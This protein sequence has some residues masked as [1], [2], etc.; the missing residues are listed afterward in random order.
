MNGRGLSSRAGRIIAAMLLAM[1]MSAA[2]LPLVLIPGAQAIVMAEDAPEDPAPAEEAPAPAPAEEAPAPPP[3]NEPEPTDDPPTDDPPTEDSGADPAGD[4]ES[5]A[6]VEDSSTDPDADPDADPTAIDEDMLDEDMLDED[7]LDED[8]LDEDMLDEDMLDEDMLDETAVDEE[9]VDEEVVDEEVVDEEVVEEASGSQLTVT[10]SAGV[11]DNAESATVEASGSGL[12]PG[13]RFEIWAFSTP[14]L[15]ATDLADDTGAFAVSVA[16]PGDLGPGEHSLLVRGTDADGQPVE[17][18]TGFSIGPDG[19]LTSVDDP[20]DPATLSAP[21]L[22]ASAKAPPYEPVVAL[23]NPTAV[24][25]TSI[26]ALAII[27]AVG[28]AAGAA[29]SGRA[30]ARAGESVAGGGLKEGNFDR[31][32]EIPD[33][34]VSHNRGWMT[35]FVPLGAAVGDASRLHRSP[36]TSYVDEGSFVLASKVASTSPL[37]SRI[38]TDG[39]PVRAIF[40]SASLLLP[41]AGVIVGIVAALTGNGIAQ[42]PALALLIILMAIGIV[43]AFAGLLATTAFA[44]VVTFSGGIIGWDSLRTL[45]GV[46]LLLVGPGIIG[47]SFRNIRR[48]PLSGSSYLWERL[49]DIVIVPLFAAYV[50]FNIATALPPLGGAAFPIADEAMTLCVIVLIMMLAK[51]GL[52]EIAARWFPERMATILPAE[53]DQAGTTQQLISGCLRTAIFIFISAAFIGNVWQLWVAGVLFLIPLLAGPFSERLPNFPGIWRLLPEGLPYLA[54]ILLLYLIITS[55]LGDS[56]SDGN[57]YARIAFVAVLIPDF[58]LGLLWLIGRNGVDED[59]VRW[60]FRPSMVVAY[61]VGGI[62]VLIAT[63]ILVYVTSVG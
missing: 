1:G 52:E 27:G 45:L 33:T 57:T 18:A 59:E 38:V 56:I 58:I 35:V 2:A 14:R 25:A 17:I 12:A 62:A 21:A 10:L 47:A 42:P 51:I 20:V 37:L 50:T 3:A 22:P 26:A 7:M 34:D 40:G 16:L 5:S 6:P 63:A 28:A 31:S 15:L 23:D 39:A 41:I 24:V 13:S 61:R 32:D 36:F 11:G 49:A 29:T 19:T 48:L 9:V 4:S 60:Y 8:M 55:L 54:F 46:S 30:A 53:V 43:D 44:L